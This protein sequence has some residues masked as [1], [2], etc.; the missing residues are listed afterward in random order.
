MIIN[1]NKNI[2]V[3][4]DVLQQSHDQRGCDQRGTVIETT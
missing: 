2:I 1:T 3:Q 4:I